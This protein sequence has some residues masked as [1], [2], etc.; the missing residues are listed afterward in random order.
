[1]VLA[2]FIVIGLVAGL[3]R[4]RI[5]GRSI[6]PSDLQFAWLVAAAF[7]LQ[8]LTFY[9]FTNNQL[10][11]DAWAAAFL[12][13]SQ[14]LLTIF[15][16][17]NRHQPGCWLLGVG[18]GLNLLVIILNGGLM[19]ISPETVAKLVPNAPPDSWQ[20]GSR[21][22]TGKDIVLPVAATRIWW[23]SD[24][25]LL[26]TWFPYRVAFSLGDVVIGVGA[27]WLLWS[28]GRYEKPDRRLSFA[29]DS[30]PK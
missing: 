8:L 16:W 12:V 13:V 5:Q 29:F 24:R 7:F 4:A 19:P 2:S 15:A 27:F 21:L 30:E 11:P 23:L 28:I 14:I 10:V 22:W 1:M 3:S 6:Q 25:F 26:P 9:L 20:I 18:V 17:C